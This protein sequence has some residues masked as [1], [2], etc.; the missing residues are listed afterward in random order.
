MTI[1]RRWGLKLKALLLVSMLTMSS[2]GCGV[3]DNPGYLYAAGV[4]S[5]VLDG[6]ISV[7]VNVI[8]QVIGDIFLPDEQVDN[9]TDSNG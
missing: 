6:L 1:R 5:G 9:G 3:W 4:S 2:W 8:G 7:S